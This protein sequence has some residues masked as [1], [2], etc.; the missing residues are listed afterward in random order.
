MRTFVRRDMHQRDVIGQALRLA[1]E[2]RTAS[3]ISR[4]T[5][6]PRSTVRDWLRSGIPRS[7]LP[8]GRDECG[9][10]R[11]PAHD[12]LALPAEYMYVLG[13]YLGD[14]CISSHPRGVYR[15]RIFLDTKYP[16][17]I[18]ACE[19]AVQTLCPTNKVARL[20]CAG[21][22]ANS[23]NG[24]NVQISAYSRGWPCLFPQHGPG[25][26]HERP[27][28]LAYWQRSLLEKYPEALLRGLIHSDGCR[29][30]N[31]GRAWRHPRYSFSN[32][33][34]DIRHIFCETCNI[35]GLHWTVARRTVYVSRMDDVARLDE[36]IDPKA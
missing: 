36:F 25:R 9:R 29:F 3:E 2:G 12:F 15:L 18:D 31:T 5:G 14:G 22:Y 11:A 20:A 6:V 16:G 7:A 17:I 28:R 10:C 24:S 26:K 19:A 32:R 34:A 27:I 8:S 21:N 35:L 13:L 1:Q 30:M 4:L 33:S 23:S